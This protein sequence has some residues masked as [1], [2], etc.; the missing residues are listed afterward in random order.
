MWVNHIDWC[1]EPV[2]YIEALENVKN[3]LILIVN[4]WRKILWSAIPM[5]ITLG[6]HNMKN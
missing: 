2:G 1:C 4:P 5:T 3:N 6:F